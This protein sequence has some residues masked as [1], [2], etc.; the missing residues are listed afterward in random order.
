MLLLGSMVKDAWESES[1]GIL[2]VIYFASECVW[3]IMSLLCCS[4]A[5]Y[6]LG[7]EGIINVYY[8]KL[9]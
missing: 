9:N 7:F 3:V 4:S 6:G 5:C 2:S 1:G 8:L